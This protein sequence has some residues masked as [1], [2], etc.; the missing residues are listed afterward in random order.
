[1]RN[2]FPTTFATLA[3]LAVPASYCE[4]P[5]RC[6]LHV[7]VLRFDVN[8]LAT[9]QVESELQIHVHVYIYIC[10]DNVCNINGTLTPHLH[11][12]M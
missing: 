3:T 12:Y 9:V 6:Q 5:L 8:R 4:P 10:T 11:A 2:A 1:M 7:H